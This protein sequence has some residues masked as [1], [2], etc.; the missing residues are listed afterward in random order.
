MVLSK[1]NKSLGI[2]VFLSLFYTLFAIVSNSKPTPTTS[3]VPKHPKNN[4]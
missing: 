3:Q 1:D 2:T 4:L